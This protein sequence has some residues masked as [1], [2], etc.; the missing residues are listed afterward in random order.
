L[1]KERGGGCYRE[2]ERKSCR[3]VDEVGSSRRE[4]AKRRRSGRERERER[5]REG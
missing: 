5:E 3:G 2:K 4:E 1:R